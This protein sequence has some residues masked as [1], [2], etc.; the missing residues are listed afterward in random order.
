VAVVSRRPDA[1]LHAQFWAEDGQD[2]FA[3][4]YNHGW[5][6]PLVTAYVGTHQLI[7]SLVGEISQPFGLGA[8]PLLFNVAALAVQILPGVF[9]VS[10]RFERAIPRLW[11]RYLIGALYLVTPGAEVHDTI[12]NVQWHLSLLV[13]MVILAEAPTTWVWRLVDVAVLVLGGLTGPLVIVLAPLAV[14]R[15]VAGRQRW[16]AAVASI[17]CALALVQGV[18]A[19]ANVGARSHAP[20]GASPRLLG[21]IAVNRILVP[22]L[23]GRES[24]PQLAVEAWPHGILIGALL[25]SGAAAAL[26][27]VL[28]RGDLRLRLVIAFGALATGLALVRPLVDPARPQWPLLVDGPNGGR[29]FYIPI[30]CAVVTGVWLLARLP[31]AVRAVAGTILGAVYVAGLAGH[32]QYPAYTDLHPS[33][34][35]A[36]LEHAAVGTQVTLP[37]NPPGW[38]MVLTRH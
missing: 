35:A 23:A 25:A 3:D 26:A 10:S 13:L 21:H 33:A 22:A 5:I 1:I 31:V 19:L 14:A 17:A 29:Y 7:P 11:V 8:A 9:I 37:I 16:H 32:W 6:T 24:T 38:M 20:L 15:W 36:R 2:F 34:E 18:T 12:T 28:W 30:V 4:A 27:V